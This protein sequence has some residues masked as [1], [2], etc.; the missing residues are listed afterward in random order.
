MKPHHGDIKI[1]SEVESRKLLETARFGHLACHLKEEL[2]FIPLTFAFEDG[3]LYSHSRLGKKIKIMRKNPQV[4]VQVEE[5][6][7]FFRWKS[8]IAWGQ[9]E[10]LNGDEVS[11]AM[12]RLIK[13]LIEKETDK[14]RSDLE[15]DI[16]AQLESAIIYRIKVEKITGRCEGFS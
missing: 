16:A 11:I 4:C 14:R 5:I 8:V 13:G 1:L 15:I 9:F 12:R 3:Y 2:Y 10:E 7:D 6:E